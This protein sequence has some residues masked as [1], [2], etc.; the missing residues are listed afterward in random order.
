MVTFMEVDV[1]RREGRVIVN[2]EGFNFNLSKSLKPPLTAYYVKGFI[3]SF[4]GRL[5][6]TTVRF[7]REQY[8]DESS[9]SRFEMVFS[10]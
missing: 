3:S 9:P 7:L 2:A 4:L 10:F 6:D 5:F 1:E 8:V